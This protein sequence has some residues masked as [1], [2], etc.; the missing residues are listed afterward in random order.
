MVGMASERKPGETACQN[1]RSRL[2]STLARQANPPAGISRMAGS[3]IWRPEYVP[4]WITTPELEELSGDF[5][6]R[7]PP[8]PHPRRHITRRPSPTGRLPFCLELDRTI[9]AAVSSPCPPAQ[10]CEIRRAW[11]A[12]SETSILYPASTPPRCGRRASPRSAWRWRARARYSP[13][14]FVIELPT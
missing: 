6:V 7:A 14:A 3:K 5:V 13:L 1:A 11:G 10:A 2:G 12:P 9:G 4:L 8:P